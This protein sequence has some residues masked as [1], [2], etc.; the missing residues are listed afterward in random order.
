MVDPFSTLLPGRQA[1]VRPQSRV[2]R[3]G[4]QGDHVSIEKTMGE[5]D[6]PSAAIWQR[7]GNI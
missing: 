1:M 2:E 7:R 6:V 4:D 5:R 3:A